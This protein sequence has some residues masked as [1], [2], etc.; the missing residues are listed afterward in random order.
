MQTFK[1]KA[2]IKPIIEGHTVVRG[3]IFPRTVQVFSKHFF[4][5]ENNIVN[6]RIL[7][8]IQISIFKNKEIV[9]ICIRTCEIINTITISLSIIPLF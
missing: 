4:I 5:V 9:I 8:Y 3:N 6:V 2:K 7:V 1:V